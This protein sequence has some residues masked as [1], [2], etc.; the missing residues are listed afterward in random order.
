MADETVQ[1]SLKIRVVKH[2]ESLQP[3]KPKYILKL[4]LE[5]LLPF[6]GIMK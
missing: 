1:K 3:S 6:F 4:K 2:Y 5:V